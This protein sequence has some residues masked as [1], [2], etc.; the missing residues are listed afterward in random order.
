MPEDKLMVHFDFSWLRRDGSAPE[1][2]NAKFRVEK[3]I[4]HEPPSNVTD[5]SARTAGILASQRRPDESH[6]AGLSES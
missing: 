4:S 3:R 2:P 1:F 6:F 5:H